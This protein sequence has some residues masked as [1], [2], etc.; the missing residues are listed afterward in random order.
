M[1]LSTVSGNCGR[2]RSPTVAIL[3]LMTYRGMALQDAVCMIGST[4]SI[5]ITAPHAKMLYEE[6]TRL[7][8]E[9]RVDKPA[10]AAHV[11]AVD[12]RNL[13]N[14]VWIWS[15]GMH[16]YAALQRIREQDRARLVASAE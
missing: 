11:L 7:W 6:A 3:Y 10:I 13:G 15:M 4:R 16:D 5:G 2:N 12:Y 1:S 9:G 8:K 14:F